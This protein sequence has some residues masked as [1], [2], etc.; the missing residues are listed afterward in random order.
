[1]GIKT[2]FIID[3]QV[4]NM[5]EL[6]LTMTGENRDKVFERL[7]KAYASD[8]LRFITK[9]NTKSP[10][11]KKSEDYVYEEELN[12]A[13]EFKATDKYNELKVG[14]LANIVLRKMLE[15]GRATSQEIE[16][17]QTGHYSKQLFGIDHP[18][19]RKASSLYE[20]KPLRYYAHPLKIWGKYY[21]LCS[22]WFETDANNDR[23]YL[24]NW[25]KKHS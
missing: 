17:M 12:P 6:A 3:E 24:E 18:L 20:K 14:K 5:F 23:L 16:H 13:I 7:A 11:S 4:S 2:M 8:A 22:E 9:Q 21:F 15:S 25:I 1:M 10:I 19:L